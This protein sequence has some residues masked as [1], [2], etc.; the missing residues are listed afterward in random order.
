MS[1][2]LNEMDAGQCRTLRASKNRQITAKTCQQAAAHGRHVCRYVR[3]LPEPGEH[4][5]VLSSLM[6]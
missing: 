5:P 4:G 6:S 3:C 1:L 2:S